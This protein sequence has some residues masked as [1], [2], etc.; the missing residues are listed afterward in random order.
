MKKNWLYSILMAI[1]LMSGLTACNNEDDPNPNPNP[2]PEPTTTYGAYIVNTGNWGANDGSIQ[3]FDMEKQTVS[4]DL[5]QAQ[6]GK[7]I[8]DVQDLCV[9]GSKM[10]AIGS[11]SSKIEVLDLSGKLLKS[12]P[13]KTTDDQPMEPRC[14]IG[15]EG[16]VFVTAYDGT[17]SKLDT[18]NLNVVGKVAVGAYPEALTYAKGKL[19]VNISGYGAGDK[20]AVVNAS[21][22][23]KEKEITVMLNP[24]YQCLT[25]AD[26]YVYVVS[27]GNYAGSDK[28]PEEQWIYQTLQR[29]DPAMDEVE[30]LCNAT[31]I[32]NKGDKMYILY[33]EYYL[34]D[35]HRCF[36]Y[37]L[38]TKKETPFVDLSTIPSPQFIAVDPVSED[39]Y[40]GNRNSGAL[41]D[42]YIYSKD[43]QF[44]KKIE[45]GNYTT[46]IRF[47]AE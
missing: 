32:A 5:Y 20:V 23:T 41:D 37:D 8:G 27:Q 16:F 36:V 7:G 4:G 42:V 45:T 25:G 26:G 6:N 10:Y 17:V 24:A 2:N 43:G 15:A 3:W 28:I 29:I 19:Y 11:T 12:I 1:P 39:V 31:Y 44:K 21:S 34:P 46:N 38:K 9:Y 14:A 22:L 13:M 33:A 18:L 35:T 47:L 40:I 30:K